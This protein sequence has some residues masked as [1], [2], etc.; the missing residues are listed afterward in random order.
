MTAYNTVSHEAGRLR[1][2]ETENRTVVV[3]DLGTSIT[4]TAEVRSDSVV[5]TGADERYELAVET[6]PERAY[7]NNG[8]LT[9]EYG[10][11]E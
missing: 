4:G 11:R 9:V 6:T 7:L 5:V 10:E 2:I 1:T 8:I 3:A